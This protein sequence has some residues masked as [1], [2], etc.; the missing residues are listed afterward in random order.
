MGL[1]KTC[2]DDAGTVLQ[3]EMPGQPL[4][5]DAGTVATLALGNLR[6]CVRAYIIIIIIIME[7][8][9]AGLKGLCIRGIKTI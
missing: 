4:I 7:K 2:R 3:T 9:E 8:T 5:K 1:S 6:T